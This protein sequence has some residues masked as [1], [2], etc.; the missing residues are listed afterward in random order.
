M[1]SVIVVLNSLVDEAQHLAQ[2][3]ESFDERWRAGWERLNTKLVDLRA[4]IISL[5]ELP[6]K[7]W[8]R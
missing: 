6:G 3:S 1:R 8:I 4:L 5:Q 2:R 7:N